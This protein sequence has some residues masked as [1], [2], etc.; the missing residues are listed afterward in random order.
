VTL[1]QFPEARRDAPALAM[2]FFGVQLH[3][4]ARLAEGQ[5]AGNGG[6]NHGSSV[7]G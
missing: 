5:N 7:H 3:Q 6:R 1:L 4:K 2:T